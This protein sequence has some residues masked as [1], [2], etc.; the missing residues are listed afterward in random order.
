LCLFCCSMCLMDTATMNLDLSHCF[1]KASMYSFILFYLIFLYTTFFNSQRI[2][3]VFFWYFPN[4]KGLYSWSR[5]NSW[6]KNNKFRS[7]GCIFIHFKSIIF[8]SYS[9]RFFQSSNYKYSSRNRIASCDQLD[10]LFFQAI[11]NSNFQITDV[12][13]P[14]IEIET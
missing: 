9:T 4:T 13:W 1:L 11:S 14:Y 8:K 2:F 12:K 3:N 6:Q 5:L 7:S 10:N